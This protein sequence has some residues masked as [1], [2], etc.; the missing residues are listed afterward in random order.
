MTINLSRYRVKLAESEAEVFAAQRLRYRVFVEEMGAA[1]SPEEVAARREWDRF[2][3]W[4]DHLLLIDQ[5]A[6]V[7]D[8]LDRVVGAYR[9]LRDDVARSGP[10]FYGASEYD[11]RPILEDGRKSVELGRSCVAKEHRGGPGMHLLWNGLAE[12]VLTREIEI[13]FGVASFPGSDANR[14]AEALALLR[15]EHLAPEDLRVRAHADH[16]VSMEFPE[17]GEIDEKR[18]RRLIPPLILAYLRFGG[19]VGEGAYVD[20]RFNTVDVCV[21]MDTR[22]MTERY[23]AFYERN[24]SIEA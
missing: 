6:E 14:Y 19:W 3:T 2:D 13:L 17:I 18:A 8:P 9:L 21:V 11:L 20:W 12:Y 5:T 1:A 15:R 4:F 7:G 10:G 16:F 24:R 22:R 23:R